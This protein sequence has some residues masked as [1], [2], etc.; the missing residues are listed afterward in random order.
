MVQTARFRQRSKARPEDDLLQALQPVE[1]R[2][3]PAGRTRAVDNFSA[4][5]ARMLRDVKPRNLPDT[6]AA[7]QQVL[8]NSAARVPQRSNRSHTGYP[9]RV[10]LAH[11]FFSVPAPACPNSRTRPTGPWPMAGSSTCSS[12]N[13]SLSSMIVLRFSDHTSFLGDL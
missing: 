9:H 10:P 5:L 8:G 6:G 11:R 12:G 1:F 13:P 4:D 2:S 3:I 7:F